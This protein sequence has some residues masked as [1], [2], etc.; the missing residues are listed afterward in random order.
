MKRYQVRRAWGRRFN[1]TKDPLDSIKDN[2]ED[3]SNP[4]FLWT[5]RKEQEY[6]KRYDK[7]HQNFHRQ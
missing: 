6:E 4:R 5:P 3:E 2:V 7:R 1:K